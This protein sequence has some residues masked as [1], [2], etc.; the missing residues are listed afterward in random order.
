M[1]VRHNEAAGRFELDLA[2]GMAVVD[3]DRMGD[4][5]DVHHTFVPASER[6]KGSG[7]VLVAEVVEYARANKLRIVPSCWYVRQWLDQHP[8]DHDVLAA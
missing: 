4:I 6:G 3:Y 5:L 1:K 8:D 2:G 7:A